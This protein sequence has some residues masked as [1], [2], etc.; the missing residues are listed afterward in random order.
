M[1]TVGGARETNGT[2]R[3]GAPEMPPNITQPIRNRMTALF[4]RNRSSRGNGVAGTD[5]TSLT[6]TAAAFGGVFRLPHW[7]WSDHRGDC[8][9][10][11]V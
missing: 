4:V 10:R 5:S 1:E 6:L 11:L 2:D 3:L 9:S 7:D 8:E